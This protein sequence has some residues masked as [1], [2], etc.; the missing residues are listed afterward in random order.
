MSRIRNKHF[1]IYAAVMVASALSGWLISYAFPDEYAAQVKI[2]DEYK[3]TDLAIGLN[4]LNVM[5]RDLNV[6]AGN[7]G[8]DDIEIY[9]KIIDSHD[10]LEQIGRISLPDSCQT[11]SEYLETSYGHRKDIIKL[12]DKNINYNISAYDHTLELQVKDKNPEIPISPACQ[13]VPQATI[14]IRFACNNCRR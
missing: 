5:M 13:D 12:I 6:D 14:T 10:F 2:S 9:S 3:T 11:Y 7:Q 4:T 1:L 8:T